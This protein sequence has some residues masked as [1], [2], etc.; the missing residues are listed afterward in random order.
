[1]KTNGIVVGVNGAFATV[2]AVRTSAC[3]GCH[4]KNF[5]L[6]CNQK[7]MTVSARNAAGALPGDTVELE[8]PSGTI[9]GY[10]AAVFLAPI[11]LALAA[12]AL[13]GMLFE[14]T[15]APYLTSLAAFVGAFVVLFFVFNSRRV[16]EHNP[17]TIVKIINKDIENE[18][19][20]D[21]P[22]A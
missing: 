11:V 3:D 4:S 17:F 2:E 20:G 19:V 18:E 13:G 10:A 9:L 22:D 14:G 21:S 15:I 7:K 8:S 5:C 1:M 6:S 12:Y 16:R